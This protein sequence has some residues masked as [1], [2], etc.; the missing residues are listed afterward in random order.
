MKNEDIEK[1]LR[2]LPQPELPPAWQAAILS[3][4]LREA[5]GVK[6]RRGVWPPLLVMLRNLFARNPVTAMALATLWIL[7]FL[8]KAT[9]PVDPQEKAM[10]AHFDPNRPVYIVSLRDQIELAQLWEEPPGTKPE[11]ANPMK[12]FFT[13][14]GR[15]FWS[16]G[17]LK[18]VLWTAT[19][20]VLFYAEEDWRGARAWASTKAKWGGEG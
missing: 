6:D 13:R 2:E 3:S 15:L 19:I 7:I 8:F 1:R 12:R 16:W 20:I 4:A 9:T 5:R 10:L 14:L 17:F 18:F 11:S